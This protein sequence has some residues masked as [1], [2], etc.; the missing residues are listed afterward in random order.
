MKRLL[1]IDYGRER[2]GVA[3]SDPLNIIARGIGVVRNT[4]RAGEEI[5]KMA[6]EFD[7]GEII[8]GLPLDLSGRKGTAAGE[9]EKFMELLKEATG[10]EIVAWDERFSSRAA[11]ESMRAMGVRKSQRQSKSSVDLMAAAI[12]LQGYL[13]NRKFAREREEGRSA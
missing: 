13:D 1:G 5:R 10:R 9:A 4:P 6:D 2:I 8:V 11:H 3:V 12:I 7:V